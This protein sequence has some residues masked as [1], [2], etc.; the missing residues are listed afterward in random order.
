[1]P[2]LGMSSSA[3]GP[4]GTVYLLANGELWAFAT[5]HP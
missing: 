1:M 3:V 4:D 2:L 5:P